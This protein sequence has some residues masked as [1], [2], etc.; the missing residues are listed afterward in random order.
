MM[1][2]IV[3]VWLS[4]MVLSVLFLWWCDLRSC[5]SVFLVVLIMVLCKVFCVSC[6][7]VRIFGQ[8]RILFMCSEFD[9][10]RWCVIVCFSLVS[11]CSRFILSVVIL[12]VVF[13]CC[14]LIW[15][16]SLLCDSVFISIL[17]RVGL[18]V[19]YFFGVWNSRLRKCELMVWNLIEMVVMF[20][21]GVLWVLVKVVW[22]VV[23]LQLVMLWI[24]ELWCVVFG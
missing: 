19:W 24:M 15:Y 8:C 11:C 22:C 6:G 18:K 10:G 7:L 5:L 2:S 23:M 13:W 14:R 1:L 12:F 3:F 20:L 16:F 21:L 4:S 9:V 17:C